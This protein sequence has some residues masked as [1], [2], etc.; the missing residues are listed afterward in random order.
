[1]RHTSCAALL[2]CLRSG[3]SGPGTGA[4]S[5]SSPKSQPTMPEWWAELRDPVGGADRWRPG[6]FK[7]LWRCG[8][9]TNPL[10]PWGTEKD[11]LVPS[12]K[13]QGW[14]RPKP[15]SSRQELHVGHSHRCKGPQAWTITSCHAA[16]SAGAGSEAEQP[17]LEPVLIQMGRKWQ[18]SH[19][20]SPRGSLCTGLLPVAL[21]ESACKSCYWKQCLRQQV[22]SS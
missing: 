15:I 20:S 3:A 11:P 21:E 18:L 2:K 8:I 4:G 1:M 14:A 9:P 10:I 12:Y 6:L 13:G 5:D 16:A 17:G 19:T 22:A 7:R